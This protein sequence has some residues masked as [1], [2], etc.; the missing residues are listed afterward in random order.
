MKSGLPGKNKTDTD[1]VWEI[2]RMIGLVSEPKER[3][4]KGLNH[5]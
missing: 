5:L 3:C 4:D 1:V 2:Q